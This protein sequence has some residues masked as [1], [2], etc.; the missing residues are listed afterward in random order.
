[1]TKTFLVVYAKGVENYSGYA[2]DILG[3]ASV[4]DTLEEMRANMKEALEFHLEGMAE[5]GTD[6]PAPKSTSVEFSNEDFADGV[7]YFIVEKLDIEI[8][9]SAGKRVR[10]TA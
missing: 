9:E 4:G 7:A 8:P 5:D 2:P 3:C 1:M 10:L 6:I